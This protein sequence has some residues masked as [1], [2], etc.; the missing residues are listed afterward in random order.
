MSVTGTRENLCA[1]LKMKHNMTY[2]EYSK[3]PT[4]KKLK[5]QADYQGRKK[6]KAE[7][8]SGDAHA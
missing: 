4:E 6:P 5:I 3:L 1:W 7:T 2:T 8:D